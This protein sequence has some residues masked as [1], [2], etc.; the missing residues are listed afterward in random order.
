[1]CLFVVCLVDGE[2][3][4]RGWTI[5][6]FLV[7][8]VDKDGERGKCTGWLDCQMPGWLH[9]WISGRLFG[10]LKVSS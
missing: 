5:G 9:E 1:M 4:G 2:K 3:V 8:Y 6:G 10:C 7:E